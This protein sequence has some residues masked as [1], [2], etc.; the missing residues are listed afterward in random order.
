MRIFRL[1]KYS[2]VAVVSGALGF[3]AGSGSVPDSWQEAPRE[4]AT[5]AQDTAEN[6][7][8]DDKEAVE[9]ALDALRDRVSDGVRR[10]AGYI[11]D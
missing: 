7:D 5:R 3:V 6:L 10:V 8:L 9:G 11:N 1:F 4:L 2:V